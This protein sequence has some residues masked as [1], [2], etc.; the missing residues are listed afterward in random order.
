ME[1]VRERQESIYKENSIA[2]L[3]VVRVSAFG[4]FLSGGTGNSKDDILLHKGQQTHE[5]K[6][7]EKVRVFLY[8][9]PHHRLTASM[10]LPQISV[11]GIGYAPVMNTTRFGA[12]VDVGTERGIFLPFTEMIGRVTEGQKVW[13]KLYEDKTGR[14]AVTMHVDEEIR[15]LALP[16]ANDQMGENLTGTVYNETDKGFF[17]ISRDRHI[18]FIHKTECRELIHLGD[19]VTGRISFIREDGH[20]NISLR[21]QKEKAMEGDMALLVACM[22]RH[23]GLLPL[24]DKSDADLIKSTLG[25]SKSAFKRAVGHLLKARRI[26]ITEGRIRL[27]K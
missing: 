25:I 21:P 1:E 23:N 6:E 16:V 13:V 26:T 22:E 7:G 5:V 2:E 17:L 10:R 3:P 4:A 12:F 19:E 14:L 15:R 24:T 18:A 9:D 20:V 11:G 27:V 8:H